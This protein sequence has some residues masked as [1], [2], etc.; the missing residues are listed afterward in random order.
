MISFT[1]T[2]HRNDVYIRVRSEFTLQ[3]SSRILVNGF[4]ELCP[5]IWM[6][7]LSGYPVITL[8][9]PCIHFAHLV[10]TQTVRGVRVGPSGAQAAP[11][12]GV[13]RPQLAAILEWH[14]YCSSVVW[15]K[16]ISAHRHSRAQMYRGHEG[17][18]RSVIF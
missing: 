10:N 8:S 11:F 17:Y 16:C 7:W 6:R 4:G 15:H 9:L 2:D 3:G 13:R 1:R 14:Q 12:W 18:F 5:R